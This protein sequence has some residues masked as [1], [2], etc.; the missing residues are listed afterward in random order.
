METMTLVV[1]LF[2]IGLLAHLF[3]D[4]YIY[5]LGMKK[6]KEKANRHIERKIKILMK[7]QI[8][9]KVNYSSEVNILEEIKREIRGI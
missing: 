5:S 2:I 4:T 8:N 7:R 6:G 9:T 1:I 3:A